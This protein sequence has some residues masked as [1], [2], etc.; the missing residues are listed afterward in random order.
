[1]NNIWSNY[2]IEIDGTAE[3]QYDIANAIRTK[4]LFAAFRSG[5]KVQIFKAPDITTTEGVKELASVMAKA[6]PEASFRMTGLIDSSYATGEC[7]DFLVEYKNGRLTAAF[8]DR[9][10]VTWMDSYNDY[11]E[12]SKDHFECPEDIYDTV[13]NSMYAFILETKDGDRLSDHVP[14][15]EQELIAC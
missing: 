3:N 11:K 2:N 1:M 15:P 9:Y 4:L 6:A 7:V 5:A 10:K 8:S 12:F 13:K 14:L